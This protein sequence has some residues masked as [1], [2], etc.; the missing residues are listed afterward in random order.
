MKKR[1]KICKGQ[2][3]ICWIFRPW[4]VL[5][6]EKHDSYCRRVDIDSMCGSFED[7]EAIEKYNQ[8]QE[9]KLKTIPGE[10]LCTQWRSR[11]PQEAPKLPEIDFR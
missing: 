3:G 6:Y 7:L 8:K 11:H 5:S 10:D 2:P 4:N 9:K 1:W